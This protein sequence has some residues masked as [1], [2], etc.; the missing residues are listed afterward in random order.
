MKLEE[1]LVVLRKEQGLTQMEIAEKIDVSRQAISKWE[2]GSA[3]PSIENLKHICELY[4]VSVDY[5]LYDNSTPQGRQEVIEKKLYERKWKRKL[6]K[7]LLIIACIILFVVIGVLIYGKIVARK[8]QNF[9]FDEMES[10][11]WDNT[12]TDGFSMSW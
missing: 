5:L 8:T 11:S 1:K 4:G 2:S 10:E 9:S 12:E 3:V 6:K 7:W